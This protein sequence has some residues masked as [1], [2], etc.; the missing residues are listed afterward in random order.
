MQSLKMGLVYRSVD[1]GQ[2]GTQRGEIEQ[3]IQAV[4]RSGGQSKYAKERV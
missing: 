3:E 4:F 2:N 1:S